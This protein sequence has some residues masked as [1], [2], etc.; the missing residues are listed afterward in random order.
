MTGSTS[1]TICAI[2]TPP[3]SGAISIIRLSGKDSYSI[4]EKI[5]SFQD[6]GK[7]ISKLE[8]NTIHYVSIVSEGVLID[9]VLLS[10]FRAQIGRAHV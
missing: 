3:G 5:V 4:C 8:P 7:K 2:A 10:L 9:E 6:K 1:D